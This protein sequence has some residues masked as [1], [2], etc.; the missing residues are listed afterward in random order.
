MFF[1]EN[2][3]AF[4]SPLPTDILSTLKSI[5]SLPLII[6]TGLLAAAK[7]SSVLSVFKTKESKTP[8]FG[9]PHFL[10]FLGKGTFT[11]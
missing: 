4:F 11:N 6:R 8:H 7:I 9:L 1:K 2:D 3:S 5:N 10:F